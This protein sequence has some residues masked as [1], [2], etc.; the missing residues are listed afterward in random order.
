VI[1]QKWYRE[2]KENKM[3]KPVDEEFFRDIKELNEF[4]FDMKKHYNVNIEII[5]ISTSPGG[6]YLY[7]YMT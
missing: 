5:S 2:V 4:I 3:I 6:L 1:S 7:Y